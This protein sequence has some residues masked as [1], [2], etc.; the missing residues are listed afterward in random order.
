[1][2]EERIERGGGVEPVPIS[3]QIKRKTAKKNSA[4]TILH[5]VLVNIFIKIIQYYFICR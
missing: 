2:K 4:F 3:G 5:L 1:M